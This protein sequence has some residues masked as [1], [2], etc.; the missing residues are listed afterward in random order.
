M[1]LKSTRVEIQKRGKDAREEATK[2][3]KAVIAKEQELI[4]VI[5][6]EES[7]LQVLQDAWDDARAAEKAERER[8][9]RAR[10]AA[11]QA[12]ITAIQ[13]LPLDMVGAS[14]EAI[15]ASIQRAGAF[16]VS[17]FAGEQQLAASDARDMAIDK[18]IDLRAKRVALEAENARMEAERAE[19]ERQ[20]AEQAEADRA[21]RERRAEEDRQAEAERQRRADEQAE[22]DRQA[23]AERRQQEDAE[24]EVR[25]RQEAED[26]AERQRMQDI[27]DTKRRAE[28]QRLADE[29]AELARQRQAEAAAARKREIANATLRGSCAEARE[30][31]IE[32][33]D[34]KTILVAKLAA[35]LKL[36]AAEQEKAA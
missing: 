32:L 16:D 29:R 26:R 27:E 4:G 22:K 24:R 2:F 5:E 30:R 3:S 17:E 28:D 9:E 20:R 1:A 33:G 23:T 6:P 13:H 21:A 18:L 14:V 36:P 31:L 11:L 19:L 10:A 15:D 7:R 35:V 25:E 12:K 34:G 8:Q